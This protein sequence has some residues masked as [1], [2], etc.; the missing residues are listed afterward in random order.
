MQL[1]LDHH[2]QYSNYTVVQADANIAGAGSTDGATQKGVAGF[3]SANFTVSANGWV[4]LKPQANPYA[5]SVLA[6]QWFR[7][8]R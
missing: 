4:Q 1:L 7:F 3:D 2:R 6:E 5:A 8:W